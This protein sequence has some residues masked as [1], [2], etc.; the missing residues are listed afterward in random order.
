MKKVQLLI[1]VLFVFFLN[2]VHSQEVMETE[3][4]STPKLLGYHFG[5]VQMVFSANK[6]ELTYIDK[7]N[8]Y[9]IGFSGVD[10]DSDRF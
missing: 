10:F 7:Y 3:K 2:R 8:F 4:M 5:V 6:G 9:T 1:L